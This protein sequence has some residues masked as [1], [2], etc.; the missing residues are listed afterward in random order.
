MS[1]NMVY[2]SID[3]DDASYH[4]C[5]LNQRTGEA[6]DFQLSPDIESLYVRRIAAVNLGKL[7]Q[8]LRCF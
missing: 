4:I 5:A 1:Q 7:G 8:T 6:L 2:V 3:F